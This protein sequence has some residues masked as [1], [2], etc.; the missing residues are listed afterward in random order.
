MEQNFLLD[1]GVYNILKF[2]SGELHVTDCSINSTTIDITGSVFGSDNLIELLLLVDAIRRIDNNT[3]INL[4]MPYCAYARQDR[5]SNIGEALSSKVFA[6]IINSLELNSI[7]TWDN[8]SDVMT[9]LLN[10]CI[11]LSKVELTKNL[12]FGQ[13]QYLVSPDAGANK[14]VNEL[15][16]I[17][18][19]PVIR[20]D[21][22]RDTKT[23]EIK[24]TVV[25]CDNLIK[26]NCLIVDD[27]C[28]GGRTFTELAKALKKKNAGYITLYTT[29]AFFDNGIE[30]LVKSGINNFIT[31]QSIPQQHMKSNR[32]SIL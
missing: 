14:Q 2:K 17:T 16:K 5:V 11:N 23:G 31:T 18:G 9:A 28:Q 21:K 7:T 25:Y 1:N 3:I 12:N 4:T 24:E 19:I 15:S 22:I 30:E 8:H 26:A 13:F 27:I 32:I 20:A 10:N 6:N 29:H